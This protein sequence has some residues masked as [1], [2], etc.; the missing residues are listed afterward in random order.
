MRALFAGSFDPVT[1]GHLD[2]ISRLAPLVDS[3][4]VGVG[5]NPDKQPLFTDDERVAMLRTACAPW[6]QVTVQTFQGL[7]VEAARTLQADLLVRGVRPDEYAREVLMA[8]AN[9][10][11]SGVETLLLP[12]DPALAFLS[13][14]VVREVAR[15]GGDV[16]RWVPAPVAARLRARFAGV[17]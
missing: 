5:V 12:A 14:S 15:F 8:Q 1:N 13:A 17:E 9:R 2:L 6:P 4:V 10:A 7:A 3:L 11:L 16:S